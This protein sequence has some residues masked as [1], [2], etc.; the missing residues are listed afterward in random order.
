MLTTL[1]FLVVGSTTILATD[2]LLLINDPDIYTTC[3]EGPPGSQGLKEAFDISAMSV[4]MDPDGIH[5]S[6]NITS[7]WDLPRTDRLTVRLIRLSHPRFM[8]DLNEL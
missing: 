7:K 6:G 3:R 8:T 1:L 5:V 2:Y 4:E